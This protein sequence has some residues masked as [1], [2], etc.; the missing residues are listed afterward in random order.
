MPK[1]AVDFLIEPEGRE[2]EMDI[3]ADTSKEAMA[4]ALT[5]LEMKPDELLHTVFAHIG[6]PR[7]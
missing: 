2:V 4:K 7:S 5:Q 3:D 6:R 1:F